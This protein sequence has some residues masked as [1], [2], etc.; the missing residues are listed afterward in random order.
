MLG[1]V[2]PA[3]SAAAAAAARTQSAPQRAPPTAVCITLGCN[4]CGRDY[5]R[6][7][8]QAASCVRCKARFYCSPKCR[9]D[10]WKLG[11][12]KECRRWR[13][14]SSGSG[15]AAGA[16]TVLKTVG[17]AAATVSVPL[18]PG[19]PEAST[20]CPS[21]DVN[22]DLEVS[23]GTHR[24]DCPPTWGVIR[25]AHPESLRTVFYRYSRAKYD[26]QRPLKTFLPPP[27][28]IAS[29]LHAHSPPICPRI[30]PGLFFQGDAGVCGGCGQ[31]F[32]GDCAGE[33]GEKIDECP[34]CKASFYSADDELFKRLSRLLKARTSST[35]RHV[36]IAQYQ[37]GL[38]HVRA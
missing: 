29:A 10:D 7:P 23:P 28:P 35:G 22:D 12:G 36:P 17:D 37:L 27:D 16:G 2:H 13:T 30:P 8:A 4:F 9:A 19:D 18:F 24:L 6:D 1:P 21:C 20:A 11:H 5:P 32:C 14:G 38:H 31:V 3:D 15:P 25:V 33:I 34:T 26:L